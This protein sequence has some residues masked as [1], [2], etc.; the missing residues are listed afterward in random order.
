MRE[1][2]NKPSY[3]KNQVAVDTSNVDI[4]NSPKR[5]NN[6]LDSSIKNGA[7]NK[8]ENSNKSNTIES[9]PTSQKIIK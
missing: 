8:N 7:E 3:R 2:E 5:F 1:N 4:A 9:D 6:K